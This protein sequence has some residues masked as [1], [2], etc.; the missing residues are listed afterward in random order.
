LAGAEIPEPAQIHRVAFLGTPALAVPVLAALDDAGYHIPLVVSRADKR[1]GRGA[2]LQPSPVKAAALE[3]GL[4]VTSSLDDVATAEVDLGVVVAFGR[5]IPA[6]LLDQ[7]LFVNVH[8]SLLPRWR[9]A[10]PVERALLAGDQITGVCLMRLE[11]TLDTGPIYG[12]VEVPIRPEATLASLRAE[13]VTAGTT[14]LLDTLAA[15]LGRPVPQVGEVSYAAK[16]AA[17]EL[18]LDFSRPAEELHRLV[19]LGGAWTVVAGRRLKVWEAGVS[20][21]ASLPPGELH[22]LEV[23]TGRGVLRLLEV[24]PEGKARMAAAAWTNGARL[25]VGTVLGQ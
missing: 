19:R 6:W 21:A 12:R 13:L 5:L 3:R 20:P 8:F 15:G 25:P 2:Q 4:T 24:Q 1:R 7:L 10:A 14:L 17:D 11:E 18:R 23:G 16:L 9:G 22:G